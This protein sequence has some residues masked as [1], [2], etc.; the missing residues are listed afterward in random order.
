MRN[1]FIFLLLLSFDIHAAVNSYTGIEEAFSAC[2]GSSQGRAVGCQVC[3]PGVVGNNMAPGYY[4]ACAYKY[5]YTQGCPSGSE[6]NVI[7]D[8]CDI[9]DYY[10]GAQGAVQCDSEGVPL[11]CESGYILSGGA[12]SQLASVDD[13]PESCYTSGGSWGQVN[14]NDVCVPSDYGPELNCPDG[15]QIFFNGSGYACLSGDSPELYPTDPDAGLD[16]NSPENGSGDQGVDTNGDGSNNAISLAGVE[17]RLDIANS[18]LAG[19]RDETRTSNDL[20]EEIAENTDGS[21]Q[22]YTPSGGWYESDPNLTVEGLMNDFQNTI[23]TGDV[24]LA[25]D[26][27]FTLDTSSSCPVWSVDAWVFS[28]VIDQFCSDNIPWVLIQGIIIATALLLAGRIAL[29]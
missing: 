6:I 15:E 14:G 17:R 24:M 10:D 13:T 1:L 16:P 20:L 19:L 2:L 23:N 11:E 28:I 5:Y 18:H 22:D 25:V 3:S 27:F 8:I 7:T 12:C 26:N 9:P 21:D 29:T 4:S